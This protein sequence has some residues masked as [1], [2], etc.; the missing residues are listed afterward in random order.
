MPT[1]L[2]LG[3]YKANA[4]YSKERS[5]NL[6]EQSSAEIDAHLNEM[7]Y[8]IIH[9]SDKTINEITEFWENKENG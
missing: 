2:L 4:S 6:A 8:D 9:V 3:V 7:F 1:L 5:L